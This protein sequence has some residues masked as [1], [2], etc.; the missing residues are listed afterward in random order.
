LSAWI[1]YGN[2]NQ[3]PVCVN[4]IRPVQKRLLPGDEF[5]GRFISGG[6]APALTAGRLSRKTAKAQPGLANLGPFCFGAKTAVDFRPGPCPRHF[7][8]GT[9]GDSCL[10]PSGWLARV[11]IARPP[12]Q[13]YGLTLGAHVS[14]DHGNETNHVPTSSVPSSILPKTG[15]RR[16]I[17]T[18]P[19]GRADIP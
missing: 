4:W 19:P 15:T 1:P 10:L 16:F 8:L 3:D 6:K 12:H 17:P 11:N 13:T 9:R 7:R 2:P 18:L 14:A 5:A